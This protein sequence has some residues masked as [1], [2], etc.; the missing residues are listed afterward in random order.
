MSLDAR[1][2][3]I[4]PWGLIANCIKCLGDMVKLIYERF[5]KVCESFLL[6]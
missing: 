6:N 3:M 4:N 2:E 1:N 5:I